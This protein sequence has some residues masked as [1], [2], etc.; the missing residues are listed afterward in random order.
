MLNV[1]F[2]VNSYY[3]GAFAATLTKTFVRVEDLWMDYSCLNVAKSHIN[4]FIENGRGCCPPTLE[5]SQ[6]QPGMG[7]RTSARDAKLLAK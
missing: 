4:N 5:Q 6:L 7:N 2:L 1:P 3:P